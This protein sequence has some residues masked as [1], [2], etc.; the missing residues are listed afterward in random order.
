MP[1]KINF[2]MAMTFFYD[3]LFSEGHRDFCAPAQVGVQGDG[4]IVEHGD[5]LDDGEA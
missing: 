4:G 3:P 2:Y 5:V 1:S